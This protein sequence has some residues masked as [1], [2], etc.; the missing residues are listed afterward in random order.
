MF[1]VTFSGGH[2]LILFGVVILPTALALVALYWI[3][4]KAVAHGIADRDR[5]SRGPQD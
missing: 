2:L 4:R 3:V 5:N 1:G